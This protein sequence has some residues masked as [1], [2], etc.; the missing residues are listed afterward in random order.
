M[1]ADGHALIAELSSATYELNSSGRLVVESKKL[2]KLRDRKSPD[3]AD[4]FLLTFAGGLDKK[5]ER[6]DD[7]Y[8]FDGAAKRGKGNNWMTA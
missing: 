1:R 2:V 4:A 8:D 7:D 6:A 5:D 3:K